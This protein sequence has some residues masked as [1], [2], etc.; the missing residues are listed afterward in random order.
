MA[1]KILRLMLTCIAVCSVLSILIS[2][3]RNIQLWL[4]SCILLLPGYY[5]FIFKVIPDYLISRQSILEQEKALAELN[6]LKAQINPHFLY[7]TLNNILCMVSR[8]SDKASEAIYLLA[9]LM[10]QTVLMST[11]TKIK[12][13]EEIT[14]IKN[15]IELQQLRLQ[16][17]ED[18]SIN[19][20]TPDTFDEILIEP[21]I[22]ITFIE[23]AFKHG[24][25][26]GMKSHIVIDIAIDNNHLVMHVTNTRFDFS[27]NLDH[28]A[29]NKEKSTGIGLAN[30]L[31]RLKIGYPQKH[32]ISITEGSEHFTVCL[33]ISL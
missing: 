12:L 29:H 20:T 4:L 11:A 9:A 16:Q 33:D 32:T 25:V 30:A 28:A 21:L 27:K 19:F 8:K 18:V 24:I 26:T 3:G 17:H 23:N 15:Y 5:A 10:R 7:N 22:L 2:S 13:S 31:K 6:F 14:Y 1:E